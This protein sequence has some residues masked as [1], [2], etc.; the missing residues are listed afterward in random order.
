MTRQT[1][2]N[3]VFAYLA[4]QQDPP[5]ASEIAGAIG[6]SVSSVS[7]TLRRLAAA[8]QV[9]QLGV[10]YSGARTWAVADAARVAEGNQHDA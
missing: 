7:A 10:A 1:T 5:T 8:G 2:A 6:A 4:R 3:Q 9:A